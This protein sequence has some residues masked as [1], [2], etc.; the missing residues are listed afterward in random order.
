ML[1]LSW[2][3]IVTHVCYVS[4]ALLLLPVRLREVPET[5]SAAAIVG[6][7]TGSRVAITVVVVFLVLL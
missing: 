2:L 1:V 4:A 3:W 6:I 7:I 5:S